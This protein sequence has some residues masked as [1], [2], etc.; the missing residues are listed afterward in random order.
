MNINTFFV[1]LFNFTGM[2]IK[3]LMA[4]SAS[5]TL[6]MSSAMVWRTIQL[7]RSHKIKV[8]DFFLLRIHTTRSTLK[9]HVFST[10]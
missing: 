4:I 6:K 2:Q 1:H 10:Q 3:I 7:Y 9:Q 5:R 8:S